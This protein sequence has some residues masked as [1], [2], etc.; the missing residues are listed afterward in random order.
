MT[1]FKPSVHLPL[2]LPLLLA[3]LPAVATPAA[4]PESA[5]SILRSMSHT[6]AAMASYQDVGEVTTTYR[7]GTGPEKHTTRFATWFSRPDRLRFV[8]Q[9]GES[10]GRIWSDGE[11]AYS[12]HSPYGSSGPVRKEASLS[13]AIAGATGVSNNAAYTVPTL[14]F[15]EAADFR[16]EQI[17]ELQVT[18]TE[19]LEGR[20]CFVIMGKH[21][22]SD[23]LY[24]LWVGTEDRLLHRIRKVGERTIHDEVRQHIRVDRPIPAEIFNDLLLPTPSGR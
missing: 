8:W 24:T 15:P 23:S 20:E 13:L 19:S 2:L 11:A 4:A 1:S 18:G 10:K 6:Y 9:D 3:F 17:E 21:P 16:L 22:R 14:L 12:R 7:M 5:A